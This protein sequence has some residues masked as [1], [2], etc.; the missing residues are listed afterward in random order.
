MYLYFLKTILSDKVD[1]RLCFM[2]ASVFKLTCLLHYH[3]FNKSYFEFKH[4]HLKCHIEQLKTF[5]FYCLVFSMLCVFS[6]KT[7]SLTVFTI[8]YNDPYNVV[9]YWCK[10]SSSSIS[11]NLICLAKNDV[12]LFIELVLYQHKTGYLLLQ[13]KARKK[14][15]GRNYTDIAV[16][17]PVTMR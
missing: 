3:I 12:V 15:D 2:S 17:V 1:V 9:F 7:L 6:I 8:F 5:C 14:S 10:M 16:V 11:Y 13:K 4:L